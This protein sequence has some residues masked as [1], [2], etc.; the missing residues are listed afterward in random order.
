MNINEVTKIIMNHKLKE[1][2]RHSKIMSG[3]Y[4]K[5]LNIQFVFGIFQ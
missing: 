1:E 2:V 3:K 5:H 4:Q